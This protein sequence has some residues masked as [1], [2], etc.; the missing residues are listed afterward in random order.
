MSLPV[1]LGALE[2]LNGM[3]EHEPAWWPMVCA[4]LAEG[5]GYWEIAQRY[6]VKPA[7]FRG[8]IGG[9][10][11]RERDFLTALEYR[12]ELRQERAAARLA[13]FVEAG[14]NEDEI[15]AGHVLKA[16]ESTLGKGGIGVSVDTG[17]GSVT[18]IHESA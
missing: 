10:K 13:G 12:K 11:D 2:T 1:T 5:K 9:D 8:W 14:I 7:L 17:G 4:E 15:N 3:L 6:G 18:I 16:I